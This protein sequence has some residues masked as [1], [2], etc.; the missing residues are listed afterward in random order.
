MGQ[1]NFE[2]GYQ[3]KCSR[4]WGTTSQTRL[5]HIKAKYGNT[6]NLLSH[7]KTNHSNLFQVA[8]HMIKSGKVPWNQIRSVVVG[9]STIQE[10]IKCGQKYVWTERIEMERAF[11]FIAYCF[12][13]DCLPINVVEG[14]GFKKMI[15]TFDVRYEILGTINFQG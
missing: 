4:W 11:W 14:A 7:L 1:F 13:K 2:K 9:Q 8:N 6:S 15:N 12:A 5:V 10:T 3:W